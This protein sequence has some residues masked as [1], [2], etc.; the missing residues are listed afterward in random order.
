MPV[1]T[2]AVVAA[3]VVLIASAG[4]VAY[5]DGAV[6]SKP[7]SD[8]N[9]DDFDRVVTLR[10][11]VIFTA[12]DYAK[13]AG[14]WDYS[15]FYDY[16]MTGHRNHAPAEIQAHQFT[17]GS[18]KRGGSSATTSYSYNEDATRGEVKGEPDYESFFAG[19]KFFGFGDSSDS[20]TTVAFGLVAY[21]EALKVKRGEQFVVTGKVV[22]YAAGT[23]DE[24][25]GKFVMLDT[26]SSGDVH[27]PMFFKLG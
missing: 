21:D 22:F 10:G 19:G 8:V 26:K 23:D 7:L 20:N 9:G 12:T 2:S 4:G 24:G 15:R 16:G 3:S 18:Q 11:Y 14:G 6:G 17:S 25:T 5:Y 13:F 27:K 1:G